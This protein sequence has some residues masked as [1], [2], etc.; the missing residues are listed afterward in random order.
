MATRVK[1]RTARCMGRNAA[2]LLF[3]SFATTIPAQAEVESVAPIDDGGIWLFWDPSAISPRTSS[4]DV[5]CN[6]GYNFQR[7]ITHI[8]TYIGSVPNQ[9]GYANLGYRDCKFLDTRTG[10][11]FDMGSIQR[12]PFPPPCPTPVVN[13]TV[14]YSY[15]LNNG[16]C[17]REQQCLV[18]PLPELPE[19]DLCAQSLEKGRGVD[20][21]GK[22]P[23]PSDELT[24]A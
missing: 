21:D 24:R 4:P 9:Y 1:Q 5:A 20:V 23:P 8:Y 10:R 19:D 22:C 13:P 11:V 15:N 3:A 17:E 2:A 18:D 12:V 7:N 16:M 6:S 14:P